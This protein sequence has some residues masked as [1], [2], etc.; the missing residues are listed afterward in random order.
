MRKNRKQL[1]TYFSG[2]NL[3]RVIGREYLANERLGGNKWKI[4]KNFITR[5][6]G[7]FCMET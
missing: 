7:L 5:T 4:L 6:K 1:N 2:V 3:Q